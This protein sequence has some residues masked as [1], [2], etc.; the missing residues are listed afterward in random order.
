MPGYDRA[1]FDKWY[2]NPRHRVKTP[3]ELARQAAFV[4]HATEWVLQRKLRTVLDVGCGE[5][6]W[7]PVLRKLRPGL[8][9]QGVD[10]SS[11]AVAKWGRKRHIVQGSFETLGAL[12]LDGP[13]D[14][15]LCVG[16]LNY[17]TPLALRAGL[18][19]SERRC[20]GVAYLELF[21]S[22]DT[23]VIGDLGPM[24]LRTPAWYRRVIA[25]AGFV[26]VGMHCYVPR[27][28]KEQVAEMEQLDR[29]RFNGSESG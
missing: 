4:V 25:D 10:P 11:Y 8:R 23:D 20:E 24:R 18:A 2:R 16:M 22:A 6:N 17:L 21:T 5:G 13:Y 15:V 7:Y 26:S 28:L 12:G 3:A 1:Y 19:A 14:L 27:R 9:Y 29:V